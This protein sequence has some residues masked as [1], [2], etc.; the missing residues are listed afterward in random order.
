MSIRVISV[1]K[2]GGSPVAAATSEY[3]DR[4]GRYWPVEL[5]EV[6]QESGRLPA[7]LV[8]AREWER[9]TAA[10]H[11]CTV[12]VCDQRGR[13]EPSETFAAWLEPHARSA[14]GIAFCIGGAFGFPTDAT[15]AAAGKVRAL[16][17]AP[18]TL[19]HGI[20]LLVLAEQLYRAGT[21]VRGEPYHK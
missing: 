3:L 7:E 6:R 10:A 16:S 19:P 14:P 17:L 21:I 8:R 4:A 20:A 12:V 9:A 13:S 11:G 15:V 18:W 1:G 5:I 2:L